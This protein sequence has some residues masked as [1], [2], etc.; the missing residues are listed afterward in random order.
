MFMDILLLIAALIWI[1]PRAK[2]AG[3]TSIHASLLIPV[4]P[5]FVLIPFLGLSFKRVF[6]R[7]TLQGDT[8]QFETEKGP[9]SLR[10]Q[11]LDITFE[12]AWSGS[13]FYWGFKDDREGYGV[14]ETDAV[15][16][17]SD[18]RFIEGDEL[19]RHIAD[20]S[21]SEPRL[22]FNGQPRSYKARHPTAQPVGSASQPKL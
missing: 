12:K 14:V 9:I 6:P 10:R 22:I 13:G 11:D 15:Y 5:L 7:V 19:A 21:G 16:W 4:T 8:L 1:L 2:T 18:H 17:S 3:F 20:W